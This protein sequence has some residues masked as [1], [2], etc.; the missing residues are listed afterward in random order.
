MME[1]RYEPRY[2]PGEPD[3]QKWK[4][5]D[6]AMH[7]HAVKCER[8]NVVKLR[9]LLREQRSPKE[10]ALIDEYDAKE[11]A[12]LG[13]V[14]SMPT[15]AYRTSAVVLPFPKPTINETLE[16]W[17][18]RDIAPPTQLIG[19]I[20]TTSKVM[21]I[22]Q[23][24]V[25]KTMFSL[26]VAGA[27][28]TGT[29]LAHWRVPEAR[30]V[31]YLDGEM[32]RGLMKERLQDLADRVG[33]PFEGRF[34]LVNR[35][36]HREM[37]P[38]DTPEGEVW[39]KAQVDQFK[40]AVVFIDNI[41]SL[42]T[43]DLKDAESWKRML[44]WIYELSD[45]GICVI[46]IHHANAGLDAKGRPSSY[47]DKTR[48]WSLDTEIFLNKVDRGTWLGASFDLKFTKHRELHPGKNTEDYQTGRWTLVGNQWIVAS[49]RDLER[50]MAET[51]MENNNGRQIVSGT[52]FATRVGVT[53]QAISRS[54]K[55]Q[56][57]RIKHTD[58]YDFGAYLAS[59]A[60]PAF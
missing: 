25:G 42:T 32:P 20:N 17:L 12:E 1:F 18:A 9:R 45:R 14:P 11:R 59:L 53:K 4:R 36:D 60:E 22:A 58:V 57:F 46:W 48:G 16:G 26:S 33:Q 13:P 56:S 5:D 29:D 24:G 52:E 6:A 8:E 3:E 2:R 38:L 47:G 37:P 35:G 49:E 10:Q 23:T 43:G 30:R 7:N 40:A 19:P 15:T 28:A 50:V 27:I 31:L 39:L 34:K 44:P 21:V 41:Q 54:P 55:W 51:A